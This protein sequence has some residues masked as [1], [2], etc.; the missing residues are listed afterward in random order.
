MKI[1]KNTILF[2]CLLLWLSSCESEF[3]KADTV[4]RE[5][6]YANVSTGR[7]WEYRYDSILYLNG[8]ANRVSRKGFL[9]VEITEKLNSNKYRMIRSFKKDSLEPYIP[10]RSETIRIDESTLQTTDHNLTFINLV[11]PPKLKTVWKGNRLFNEQTELTINDE[12]MQVYNGWDY[13][14]INVDTSVMIQNKIFPK[15]LIVNAGPATENLIIRRNR[16][17]YYTKGTGLI[18][19]SM[20]VLNTQKILPAVPWKEKAESGFIYTQELIKVQ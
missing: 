6:D 16:K 19:V 9:K 17:E 10:M 13:E 3:I 15:T 2:F 1:F 8:G 18:K 4:D 20:E 11:F 12:I 7:I 5:L 14:I